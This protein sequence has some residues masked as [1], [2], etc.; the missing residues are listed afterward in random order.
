M[1]DPEGRKKHEK[2]DGRGEALHAHTTECKDRVNALIAGELETIPIKGSFFF[3]SCSLTIF[4]NVCRGLAV[5]FEAL[6]GG[7]VCLTVV[8]WLPSHHLHK[9]VAWEDG[10]M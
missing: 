7:V 3:L 5:A 1:N 2:V 4:L 6:Q 10:W 8:N 9:R